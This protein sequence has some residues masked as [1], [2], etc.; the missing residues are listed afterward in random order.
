MAKNNIS[1]EYLA[2]DDVAAE[3]GVGPRTVRR[4]IADGTLPA[5]RVGPTLIRV[6]RDDVEAMIRPVR[7]VRGRSA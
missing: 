1:T 6:R 7:P 3:L 2:V 4:W 5:F